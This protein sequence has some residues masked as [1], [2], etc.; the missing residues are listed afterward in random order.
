MTWRPR[1]KD[2]SLAAL[3]AD[4][5]LNPR[6]AALTFLLVPLSQPHPWAAAVLVDEL[7]PCA[8]ERSAKS[9][10]IRRCQGSFILS[11]FG[12]SDCGY[13]YRR[14]SRQILGTPPDKCSASSE[15]CAGKWGN[16]LKLTDLFRMVLFI[17][18]E[19]E[20]DIHQN[21]ANSILSQGGR[22]EAASVENG[23]D[24]TP[25]FHRRLRRPGHHGSG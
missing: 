25:P 15:L 9:L 21:Q 4:G 6:T 7:D 14:M 18:Y 2:P 12:P 16:H 20:R 8:F 11:Q 23:S 1:A 22:Y 13:P 19:T 10:V 5:P 17:P 24:G 3:K